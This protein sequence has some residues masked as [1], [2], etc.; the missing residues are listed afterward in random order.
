MTLDVQLMTFLSGI[1]A[2]VR[3]SPQKDKADIKGVFTLQADF[4]KRGLSMSQRQRSH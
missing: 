3:P 1:K 2:Q 4:N